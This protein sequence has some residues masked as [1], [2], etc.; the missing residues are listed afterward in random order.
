MLDFEVDKL[1]NSI[2]V[3][4]SGN[5][6]PTLVIPLEKRE[7]KVI[8]SKTG[9]LFDWKSE[10]R[11]SG[12]EVYKLIVRNEPSIIHGLV[13][14]R[15]NKD[16]VLMTLLESAPFNRGSN[17][18][19]AGVPGNLVAFACNRSYQQGYEGYVVFLSKTRLIEHYTKT[20]GAK[21]IGG[22]RMLIDAETAQKLIARYFKK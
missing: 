19:F 11:A 20:L 10:F 6:L 13:A 12:T 8:S 2:E 14:L 15:L 7:L 18:I 21:H 5:S 4:A 16:H 22:Q 9:W 17:K 1:T 3:I